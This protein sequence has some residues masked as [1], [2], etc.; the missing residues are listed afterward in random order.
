MDWRTKDYIDLYGKSDF[1][2][3]VVHGTVKEL[4]LAIANCDLKFYRKV[5]KKKL[6]KLTRTHPLVDLFWNVNPVTTRFD[7]WES[8]VVYLQLAGEAP[9]AL[10]RLNKLDQP[11]ELW[12]LRPDFIRV[13]PDAKNFVRGYLYETGVGR[14]GYLPNELIFF[15]HF[16]PT[17]TWRGQSPYAAARQELISE[18][19]RSKYNIEFFKQG[20]SPSGVF[21]TDRTLDND[22]F[23]RLQKE[24]EM[25]YSGVNKAHRPMLLESG[26]QWTRIGVSPKDGDFIQQHALNNEAIAGVVNVPPQFAFGGNSFRY[27]NVQTTKE[28]A[29]MFWGITIKPLIRKI[30][31][32]LNTFLVKRYGNDLI[33]KFDLSEIDAIND[34]NVEKSIVARRM[35]EI[36]IWTPNEARKILWN[37]EETEDGNGDTRY[38]PGNLIDANSESQIPDEPDNGKLLERHENERIYI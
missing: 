19:Y 27:G 1:S 29:K 16:S 10:E 3:A 33:A 20:A 14:V 6:K 7:F 9:V 13:I 23:K 15:K 8:L 24:L 12:T 32:Y 25:A 38:V 11:K 37:M 5:R 35:V 22:T 17:E 28:Q 4:A 34:T 21:S 18:Y 36:G 2:N 31:E 26:L 30:E